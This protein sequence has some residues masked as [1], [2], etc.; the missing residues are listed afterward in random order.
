MCVYVCM[1]VCMYVHTHT[2]VCVCVRARAICGLQFQKP[3][4]LGSSYVQL[5]KTQNTSNLSQKY[6]IN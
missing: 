3:L 5:A 2:R 1:Y 6:S 4:P